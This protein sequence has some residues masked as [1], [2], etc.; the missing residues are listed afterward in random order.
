MKKL[1]GVSLMLGVALSVTGCGWMS[2][3][4]LD[5]VS[6]GTHLHPVADLT[7]DD[8]KWSIF[9][10]KYSPAIFTDFPMQPNQKV[11][12]CAGKFPYFLMSQKYMSEPDKYYAV[13][14]QGSNNTITGTIGFK[15]QCAADF[16]ID[17]DAA[18]D[19]F[20]ITCLQSNS[21]SK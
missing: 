18:S 3:I 17:D 5:D 1:L 7:I 15:F 4:N 20:Y 19:T 12:A 21:R 13:C 14:Y 11:S 2:G 6:T 9:N 8:V 10:T 16:V